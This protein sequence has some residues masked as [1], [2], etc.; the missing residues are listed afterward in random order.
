[1]DLYLVRFAGEVQ[2]TSHTSLDTLCPSIVEGW[3]QLEA[4]YIRNTCHSLFRR[5]YAIAKNNEVEL[6]RW[7]ANRPTHTNQYFSRLP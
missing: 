3:D 4:E 7:L 1:M 6:K 5:W 2:V